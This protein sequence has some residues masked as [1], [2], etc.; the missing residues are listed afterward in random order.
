MKK[1]PV[2]K[3]YHSSSAVYGMGFLGA[4][5]Y[6][7]QQANSLQAGLIGLLKAIFW[8]AFLV[9]RALDLLNM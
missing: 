1:L 8:P 5:V 9:H 4:L 6:Y 3:E 2:V 7:F